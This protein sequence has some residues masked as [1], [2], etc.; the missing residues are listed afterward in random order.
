MSLFLSQPLPLPTVSYHLHY[1]FLGGSGGW[2]VEACLLLFISDRFLRSHVKFRNDLL[3]AVCFGD[4]RDAKEWS[5]RWTA[6]Q[7][8]A[9]LF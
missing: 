1:V 6:S 3:R 2:G 4:V 9:S 7:L 5:Y 8:R